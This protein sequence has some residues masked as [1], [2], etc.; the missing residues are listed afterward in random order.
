MEDFFT[1]SLPPFFPL[2]LLSVFLS[3]RKSILYYQSQHR[4]FVLYNYEESSVEQQLQ[5]LSSTFKLILQ[6][7]NLKVRCYFIEK[8]K[9]GAHCV[10]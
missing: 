2:F 5:I 4:S 7:M 3:L 6:T 1:P 9:K 8:K 10:K